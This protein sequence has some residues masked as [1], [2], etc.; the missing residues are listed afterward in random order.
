MSDFKELIINSK[1]RDLF[2]P[3][4]DEERTLLENSIRLEGCRDAIITWNNQIVDGHNRYVICGKHSIPFKTIEMEFSSEGKALEWMLKNQKGRRNLSD[5]AKVEAAL[6]VKSVMEKEARDRQACGQGGIL[7][8]EILPEAS[9]GDT[10]DKI[11]ELAGVS[12]KTVDKVE[13]I[14]K[15]APE[16]I[17]QDL[18]TGAPGI[19]I[20]KAY[21]LTKEEEKAVVTAESKSQFNQSNDNIEW[22]KWSWNPITGCKHGCPYCYAEDIANRFY[23]EG[24]EPTFRPER[25]SAPA[26]TQRPD[27]ADTD[28]G[29]KNVFVCS[30]A[31]LFG[32]WVPT[33]WINAVLE[34]VE[35]NQQ[36]NFLFLTKNP[37]RLLDFVFPKNAWVGTSVDTQARV[38]TAE[39]VFSKLEAPVK[40]LS[41]EPLLEPLKFNNISVFDWLLIGSRSKNSRGPAFKPEWGWVESLL[42]Q[43]R[44]AGVKVYFKPNLF[45]HI[46]SELSPSL[47][48]NDTVY[49][50]T[51]RPREY[52][53]GM[54]NA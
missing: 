28:I 45:R 23:K 1:F 9:K 37:K 24:F 5:Y 50:E 38:Q 30:M 52:P 34:K 44:V 11:G 42:F 36:W 39:E 18:R 27:K 19:S 8:P 54:N 10:R 7:L 29:W 40:F 14:Q 15:H 47:K 33:E 20:N 4:S 41:C 48:R 26:N 21:E 49:P 53:G 32:E 3:L 31:D 17:K 12:G 35:E 25:L 6:L 2:P 13:Y 51:M 16:D 46:P 22:A 43:A